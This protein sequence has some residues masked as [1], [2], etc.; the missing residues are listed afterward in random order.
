MHKEHHGLLVA[1]GTAA[2][3]AVSAILVRYTPVPVTTLLF[4]R[5]AICSLFVLPSLWQRRVILTPTSIRLHTPRAVA[6]LLTMACFLYSIYH[7][8]IMDALTFSNTT[9]IFLP[10]VI[11]FWLKQVVTKTRILA[12]L[13]GFLGVVIILHPDGHIHLIAALI[14]LFGGLCGAFVQI[15]IKQL[16]ITESIEKILTHYFVI[17]TVVTFFPMIY[18]WQPITNPIIWINLGLIGLIAALF[19]YCYARSLKYAGSTKVSAVNYLAIPFGGLLG[20]WLF[21]E[22]PSILALAGTALIL[23]GGVMAILSKK[24]THDEKK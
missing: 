12:L 8:A 16:S 9:P 1:V 24:E 22:T 5:F 3:S 10:V 6:G 19:Q 21:D 4:F 14:G 2:L 7:L 23:V 18:F 17:I 11:F 13:I 20:W 15:G